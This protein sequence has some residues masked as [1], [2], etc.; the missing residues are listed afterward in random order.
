M[1]DLPIALVAPQPSYFG[2]IV[3]VIEVVVA[4][5]VVVTASSAAGYLSASSIACAACIDSMSRAT[6]AE[7]CVVNTTHSYN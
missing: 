6:C 4:V 5:F 7:H 3:E 1:I 2:I